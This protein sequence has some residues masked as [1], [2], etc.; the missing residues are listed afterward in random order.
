MRL[1]PVLRRRSR[2][3]TVASVALLSLL[4]ASAAH[5]ANPCPSSVIF[6][7]T[8]ASVLDAGWTGLSQQ[9]DVSGWKL[10]MGTA[11]CAGSTQG[12]CGDCDVTGLLATAGGTNQRCE[13]DTS[14]VCT[15]DGDCPSGVCAFFAT[16]PSPVVVGGVP[17]C[18]VNQI[19][20]PVTG[21]INMEAGALTTEVPL[22]SSI[23]VQGSLTDPCPRCDG[24]PVANDNAPGG[25][26]SNGPRFGLPCDANGVGPIAAFGSTS[27][28]C[29]PHPGTLSGSV[30]LGTVPVVGSTSTQTMTL[31]ATN[32]SCRQFGYT[33][34]KCFCETCNNGNAESCSSNADCPD[35]AGPIGPI[36]GGRRCLGGSN[37]GAACTL[38]SECPGGGICQTP[39]EPTQPNACS[40]PDG[41]PDGC[42]PTTGDDGECVDGP[43]DTVCSS[44]TYRSCFDD[45]DCQAPSCEDCEPGETCVL[46]GRACYLDNG[47]VGGS[48]SATGAAS[49]RVGNSATP[50]LGALF[51]IPP[52]PSG[53]VNSAVGLPGLGRLRMPG[54]LTFADE[55]QVENVGA[56][57]T[58]STGGTAS[59]S[60]PVETAVTTSAGGSGGEVQIVETFTAVDDPAPQGYTVLGRIVE[61]TA[62]AGTA[63]QPL[64]FAFRLDAS[65]AG[66]ETPAT[67]KLFR[68]GVEVP[69]CTGA[70]G[71]AS[72]DPCV[73]LR[74]L[75]GDDIVVSAYSSAASAWYM[76][77]STLVPLCDPAPTS[78][79]I[80]A[81]QAQLKYSEKT[82]GKAKMQLQWKKLASAT[83][84]GDFGDPVAG[85]TRVALC[86]YD[87]GNAL[88]E[89][90]QVVRAAQ[91]CA[92]KPCWKANGTKGFAYKDK[93]NSAAGV[94]KI[95]FGAGDAGKGKASAAGAN[96]AAKN[97]TA[98][99][100]GVV[101]AL[102]GSLTP[103]IQLVTS[104]G[105]CIGASMTVVKKDAGGEYAAQKK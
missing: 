78:P 72:P 3:R 54:V 77:E 12:S 19:V 15:L 39:G 88:V 57:E 10:R 22:R 26:C 27:F 84:A 104:D 58:V 97:M 56:G 66:T 59:A 24:D 44:S 89:E 67:L 34:S 35:P 80:A 60:D 83:T 40:A 85:D 45:F 41:A 105:L 5:A 93:N 61:I 62:P 81:G 37:V 17:A 71:T 79:C 69:P 75:D 63:A 6:D 9:R 16:L 18:I 94:A 38:S 102:T 70:P 29:P 46:R 52:A 96:N 64:T 73:F 103:T 92:G 2:S 4:L 30:S 95:A 50:T 36:C 47:L 49:P 90:L 8:A 43:F 65:V 76:T 25:I 23:Y 13:V 68:N 31:A 82:P 11:N 7:A 21:T 98:L 91:L 42:Q 14:I 100:T 74:T 48:V 32:P 28:D 86:L 51:C 20:G 1:A 33:G 87:Q 53:A 55:V 99:P 101:A